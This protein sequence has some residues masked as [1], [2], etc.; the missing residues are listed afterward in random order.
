MEG[1][2]QPHDVTT[3]PLVEVEGTDPHGE[4]VRISFVDYKSLYSGAAYYT[5]V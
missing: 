5:A 2:N 1:G 4:W 3:S